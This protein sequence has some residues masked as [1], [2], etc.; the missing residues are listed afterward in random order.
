M[1]TQDVSGGSGIVGPDNA[2]FLEVA[3]RS[4]ATSING[5]L[6]D[7]SDWSRE[8]SEAMA[9]ADGIELTDD[10]WLLIDFLHR[11]FT[12]FG[13]APEMAV[14]ARERRLRPRSCSPERWPDSHHPRQTY[15]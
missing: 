1:S 4:I 5:F 10:H 8:V 15:R 2:A 9:V 12:E 14:L 7:L 3:G 13:I 11:F 6:L